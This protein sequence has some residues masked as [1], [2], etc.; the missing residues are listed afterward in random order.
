MSMTTHNG[1]KEL[2]IPPYA[3]KLPKLE[4]IDTYNYQHLIIYSFMINYSIM[5]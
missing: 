3:N 1:Y 2:L 4:I 5:I